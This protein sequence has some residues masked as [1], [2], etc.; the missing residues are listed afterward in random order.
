[1]SR[2]ARRRAAK[3]QVKF[4]KAAKAFSDCD[5]ERISNR[6]LRD[7]WH[8]DARGLTV[9]DKATRRVVAAYPGV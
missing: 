8:F 4:D 9:R 3:A 5:R 6:H 2:A 1:M 7:V